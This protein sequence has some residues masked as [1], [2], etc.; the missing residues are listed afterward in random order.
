MRIALLKIRDERLYRPH[1]TFE[2]YCKER[3]DFGHSYVNYLMGSTKVIEHLKTS[4]IVEVLP[5]TESQLRPLTK[6]E[7]EQQL[8]AWQKV[9]ETAPE[10]I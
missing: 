8:I 5:R 1:Q 7:P 3:W 2:K 10:G 6:L 9:V 4:T